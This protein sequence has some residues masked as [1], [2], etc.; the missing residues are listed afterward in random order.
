[1]TKENEPTQQMPTQKKIKKKCHRTKNFYTNAQNTL[2]FFLQTHEPNAE[3]KMKECF[4]QRFKFVPLFKI[5]PT[6]NSIFAT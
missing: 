4:R 2:S 3:K 5:L 6:K 1:M